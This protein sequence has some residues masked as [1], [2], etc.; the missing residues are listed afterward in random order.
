MKRAVKAFI[1]VYFTVIMCF[2]G[3]MTAFA[4]NVDTHSQ[5]ITIK[6]A[7]EGT[8]FAD[9]LVKD[10]KNDKYAV[11]FNEENGKLLGVGKDCGL[12]KYEEGGY[13]SMLLRHNCAVFEKAD[14]SDSMNVIFRLKD[15]N[16]ML[17]N[18]FSRIKVAYC[19]KNGD[20]LGVTNASVFETVHFFNTP[21]AYTIETN[22]EGIYCRVSTGPPYYMMVVVP[23]LVL[24][25]SLGI[26]LGIIAKR[27]RKKVQT[28][29]M[30]KRIQSGEVD[31]ERKE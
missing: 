13:T 30:I 26:V 4:W 7:P 29:K 27:L 10:K 25:P 2:I 9:I 8:A 1:A 31:N 6:N 22:G 15:E 23:V 28:D 24:V 21:A 19:D 17:F 11:D 16:D 20:I 18:H 14:I 5:N 12:A 3:G